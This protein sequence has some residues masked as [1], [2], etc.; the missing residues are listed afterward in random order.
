[1]LIYF[2]GACREEDD[3]SGRAIGPEY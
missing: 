1:L 3:T 2:D